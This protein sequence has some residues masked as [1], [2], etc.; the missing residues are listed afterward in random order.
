LSL[1]LASLRPSLWPSVDSR[2]EDAAVFGSREYTE[3]SRPWEF[4]EGFLS[5]V[6]RSIEIEKLLFN[7]K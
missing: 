2:L 6:D 4:I 1:Y 5:L 3:N 7:E